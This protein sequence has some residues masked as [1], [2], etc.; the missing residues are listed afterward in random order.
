MTPTNVSTLKSLLGRLDGRPRPAVAD[1]V[2]TAPLQ[3][4]AQQAGP[5]RA[6]PVVRAATS[7]PDTHRMRV[8][9]VEVGAAGDDGQDGNEPPPSDSIRQLSLCGW[10]IIFLFFG[11][12][13]GWALFAPLRGAVVANGVVKVEGNRKS[14]Q[15]LDGGIVKRLSV[16]EGDH[17]NAGDL[18]LTLDDS[19]AR[20]EFQVLRQQLYVLR[21]TG[22]R[23]KA[24]LARADGLVMPANLKV[25]QKLDA[26]VTD[27]WNGQVQQFESR[28]AALEGQRSVLRARIAQY[29]AQIDGS[30]A[31]V[32]AY[33]A[34]LLS[35]REEL[36]SIDPLVKK[37]LTSKPRQLQL[38]RTGAQ[39]EGEVADMISATAKARQAIAEQNQ[40][41][42]Q[43]DNERFSDASK[44]LEATQAKELEILSRLDNA[45]AVFARTEIRAPYSGQVVGL[46]VFSVG[47][48]IMRGEKIL[49][50]VPDRDSLVIDA[51]IAVDEISDV[52]PD[53][54]AEVHLT[55]YKQRITP[56][57][58]GRVVNVS[59]DRLVDNR[60]NA[61]YYVAEI[62]IDQNQLSELPQVKLYPGMPANVII[63]TV[64]RTAFE[65]IVGPLTMT[66]N[67][68]FRQ[69]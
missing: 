59:A 5:V 9:H 23:L 64:E 29:E 4:R 12:L 52:H 34:Q 21:A 40:Q 30:E 43:L 10:T 54:L 13:G 65:Y 26:E 46:T 27:I 37:G 28:Q 44:E 62:R 36:K 60:T 61:P 38:E 56:M 58:Q 15:H 45:K 20:A 53:M 68:A 8:Q 57:V 35:V 42:V 33:R 63:P 7:Q 32:N 50:L 14:V 16:K 24:E 11:V 31:Q 25:A 19:Q 67:K 17:V 55:A 1:A 51:Q 22:A 3:E 39:L 48:V 6:I 2:R 49:D 69:K 41:I 66:F 47:G 18:L